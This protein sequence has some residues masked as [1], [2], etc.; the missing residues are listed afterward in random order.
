[1]YAV[2]LV[3]N[4]RQPLPAPWPSSRRSLSG[5]HPFSTAPEP[6]LPKYPTILVHF[7]FYF[8]QLLNSSVL[9]ESHFGLAHLRFLH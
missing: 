9:G 1:M 5:C 2:I 4:S 8:F 3:H 7:L 6:C